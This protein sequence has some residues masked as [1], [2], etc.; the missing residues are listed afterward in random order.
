[1]FD[2]ISELYIHISSY[3]V[4]LHTSALRAVRASCMVMALRQCMSTA[5]AKTQKH[6]KT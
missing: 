1:M 2:H 3:T 4:N 5:F 6:N